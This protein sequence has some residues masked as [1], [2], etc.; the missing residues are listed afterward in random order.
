MASVTQTIPTLTG[1]I[2]QQPD[3]LKVPG[4]VNVANNVLPDVTQG[5]QKRPGG[6]FVKSL[7]DGTL[8][9]YTTGKWF[10][11]YRD[12]AEQYIGQI[13]RR[14]DHA[15]NGKIRMWKCSDGS[16]MTVTH[17]A[18]TQTYLSHTEDDQL[19]TLT[20][21]D[22]TYITNRNIT[23]T[24]AQG[25]DLEP[26]RPPEAF[27]ELKQVAYS[28]QYSV[29]LFDN[30]TTQTTSTATRIEVQ[31]YRSSNNMCHTDGSLRSYALRH[32]DSNR[33]TGAGGTDNQTKDSYLPNVA[34]RIFDISSGT[35]LTDEDVEGTSYQYNVSVNY[36]N[37]AGKKNLYFRIRT[38]GQ[39]IPEGNSSSPQYHGRYTTTHD[40][41]YG[42]EGWVTGDQFFVWMKGA[43]YRVTVTAHSTTQEQANLGL[44]RPD[45]TPFDTETTITATGI[46]GDLRKNIL[47]TSHS[48][49]NS[50]YQWKSDN[51]NGYY[52][53]QIGNGLY[54]SRPTSEGTFNIST[55]VGELLNVLTDSVQDVSDL[56]NVCKHGY[57]VKV[58]NS[59]NEEDD[60][61]VKFIG[62][63]NR[64]GEGVWEECLK[65]GVEKKFTASTMP[66]QLRR[67]ANGTFTVST[68]AW[69]E[70]QVGDTVVDGTNPQPSFVGKTINKM[71]FYRNR[72]VML[73]D[74]NVIM[75]RPGSFFNFWA[76]T[77]ITFAATDPIDLSCSSEYPAIVYDGIQINAGLVLFTKNQQFMLTTDSDVLS[78]Q[79]AKINAIASYNFNHKTNP[80]SLGTTIAFM[81]NANKF[82]RMFEMARILRE[83][84]PDVV[85]QSKVVSSLLPK[86]LTLVA[87]SRENSV[88]FFG[89]KGGSTI[90]GFRYF[91]S[92]EKRLLQAWFEWKLVGEIQY[93]CMLD[94]ALYVVI[95]N[96][97]KDQLLKF[98]IRLDDNGLFATDTK[99]TATTEDDLF[100][101]V[102]LDNAKS[103]TPSVTYNQATNTS[104]FTKP[105][106][107]E[108][109]T[110][111]CAFDADFSNN[112]GRFSEATVSGSTI[113][114]TGDWTG[115]T[116]ILG[117]LF[118]MA[119]ELPT[120]YVGTQQGE[121]FR[122]NTRAYLTIHRLKLNFTD[123]GLYK[124]TIQR[125]GKTDY[126]E[127]YEMT[128][129]TQVLAN[130][131]TTVQEVEQ[132]VPIYERNKN[133]TITVS[134]KH[135][136]PASLISLSWE[137]D[138]N[139]KLYRRV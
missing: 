62:H 109:T 1:G 29:N 121:K 93:I 37:T 42:G 74:E 27:I 129:A 4:Q 132:T 20:V 124:T 99:G 103:I 94:D 98:P 76:N 8:N 105:V 75:S 81:D 110:D 35:Q 108:R 21:N 101:R 126:S 97:S 34:T 131:L 26:V 117:Y 15:D 65:P 107:F 128:P 119:I 91:T 2:S 12:E 53:K 67:N 44:V 113:S 41:L 6:K 90:Q 102:H 47:G 58:A 46:L 120:I 72:L 30:D 64:D 52:V 95:R 134:S 23:V 89:L 68:V 13:I 111:L 92:S 130:R 100:Y 28:K 112:F 55:P 17:D 125:L 127:E 86:E 49:T 138:V 137:G 66:V 14:P 36:N 77:A 33:C 69:D 61:Y 39:A 71:L 116:F 50:S 56:P 80:I 115:E 10:H 18:G 7:S 60:Y 104:T 48:G 83:G 136:L 106:G 118:D 19:Q 11:Y 5:L 114:L 54:I 38:T 16:E 32:T 87:N 84:E 85:E 78:P 9:S 31:L 122:A 133:V 135:P 3:E 63:N 45:P 82:S 40:L 57:V 25:T 88:I 96:N 73:S 24:M 70:A 59:E 123:L 139:N 51:A 22:F 43:E 79:T